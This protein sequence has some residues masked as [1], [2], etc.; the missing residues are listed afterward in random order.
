MTQT[1]RSLVALMGLIAALSETQVVNG[2]VQSKTATTSF[3]KLP[4]RKRTSTDL[5]LFANP[6]AIST[7]AT[8]ALALPMFMASA[9]GPLQ[10]AAS[11]FFAAADPNVEAAVFNDLAHVSLDLITLLGPATIL[12]RTAAVLGR[13]FAMAA[14]YIPDHTVLPG[15]LLF[16]TFMLG[17]A[18]FA[19]VK[20]A[21]PLAL[22][23]VAAKVSVRD[24][25]AF[26][27]LFRPAG[28]QWEQY[29]ALSVYSLDW[30]T[31]PAGA[32]IDSTEQQQQ[33]QDG[34]KNDYVYWLYSGEVSVTSQGRE[35]YH[36]SRYHSKQKPSDAGAGLWGESSLFVGGCSK[37]DKKDAKK[38]ESLPP[39]TL[40]AAGEGATLLRMHRPHLTQLMDSDPDLAESMRTLVFQGMQAK[41]AAQL[42]VEC[43]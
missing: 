38:K 31:V 40:K 2:Y 19:L 26:S 43:P 6:N 39:T 28:L 4:R 16:Q 17:I 25:K 20:A 1:K 18:W 10:G 7:A 9:S 34:N 36:V 37:K 42:S 29:K 5:G 8:S 12:I 3:T 21:M 33:Q 22:S 41:L 27:A 35:L 14:D 23:K 30:V 13:L 24:G 32:E 11:T 15:E